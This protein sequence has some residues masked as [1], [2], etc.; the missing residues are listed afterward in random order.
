MNKKPPELPNIEDAMLRACLAPLM[1]SMS[2][3]VDPPRPTTLPGVV[4]PMSWP[5][6]SSKDN[7][8]ATVPPV[9]SVLVASAPV[10]SAP[11]P[12]AP[13]EPDFPSAAV[14][15]G[16]EGAMPKTLAAWRS[17]ADEDFGTFRTI[18]SFLA[19]TDEELAAAAAA[20][21]KQLGGTVARL[22]RLRERLKAQADAVAEVQILLRRA[23]ARA[24]GAAG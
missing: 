8:T 15:P 22:A 9:P 17:L 3:G 5:V 19:R 11:V 20:F 1:E 21:P 23:L 14:L 12:S 4:I 24:G 16:D 10:P 7:P 18:D 6:R 2:G 13:A